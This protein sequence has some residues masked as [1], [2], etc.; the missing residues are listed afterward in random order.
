MEKELT[1]ILQTIKE[2]T[3]LLVQA[4]SK[5]GSVYASTLS[6]FTPIDNDNLNGVTQSNGKTIFTFKFLGEDFY[7]L[8]LGDT[9]SERRYAE[10]ISSFIEMA[11]V[12]PKELS[13]EERLSLII[14]GNSPKTKTAEF[15]AEY[16]IPKTPVY[17]MII[18][19]GS[20]NVNDVLEFLSS[21]YGTFSSTV[22][23]SQDSCA[24][25]SYV[26]ESDKSFVISP[27]KQAEIL[28]RSVFEELGVSVS[29]YVGATVD[30]F[31]E[32]ADSFAQARYAESVSE[33]FGGDGV[34]AYKDYLLNKIVKDL[35]KQN[36]SKFLSALVFDNGNEIFS[37][38][39]LLETGDCF[40]K[41][42]LNLS[43]TAR[44]MYIHRNT[45]TYRLEKIEKLTGLDI[46][47]FSDALNFRILYILYKTINYE[48]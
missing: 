18:K 24:I 26:D 17:I 9:I 5:S 48:K 32:I 40:L 3:G 46:K 11:N 23:L 25:V 22:Q 29:V 6:E 42:N 45:L 1:R 33:I 44:E 2:K 41:N 13:Y 7:G 21:Y 4:V 8:I 14:T 35:P 28:K 12:K 27:V 19:L 39:E 36:L 15:I 30:N 37:D 38:V 43:E 31:L 20:G 47:K 16:S 34:Y 10:L